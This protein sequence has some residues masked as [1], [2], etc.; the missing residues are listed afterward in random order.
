M[1]VFVTV[2]VGF[3]VVITKFLF[4]LLWVLVVHVDASAAQVSWCLVDIC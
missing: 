1:Q 3:G 4:W 2:I